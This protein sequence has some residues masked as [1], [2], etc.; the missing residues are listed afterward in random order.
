M[1]TLKS[2]PHGDREQNDHD[3]YHDEAQDAA[4]TQRY[5][6]ETE[7][8]SDADERERYSSGAYEGRYEDD[9]PTNDDG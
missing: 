5:N 9:Y 4:D 2:G 3:W 7:A 6:E 1:A 8:Q